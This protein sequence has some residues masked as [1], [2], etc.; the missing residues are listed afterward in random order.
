MLV[1]Y[2]FCDIENFGDQLNKLIFKHFTGMDVV[3]ENNKFADVI[4]IGSIL[5]GLLLQDERGAVSSAPLN[6]FSSGF[7]FDTNGVLKRCLMVFAVRGK[8][9]LA[10]LKKLDSVDFFYKDTVL[11][12]GGVLVPYLIEGDCE[13]IYDLGIV[14]HYADKDNKV[15]EEIKNA[16]GDKAVILDP[17]E[18]PIEFLKKLNKC[19]AVI[20]T[21][22][23]PLIACDALRIPNMWV[24][25]S[26][27]TTS[28]FKFDDYYS[29]FDLEKQPYDLSRGFSVKDLKKVYECYDITDEAVKNIQDKLI[30]A[31]LDIKKQLVGDADNINVRYKKHKR[32][33]KIMRFICAFIPFKSV[34]KIFRNKY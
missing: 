27:E 30:M 2:H 4:G 12:D 25:I 28:R 21:A 31:L 19:K 18:K 6:V 33:E 32:I 9:T 20:S 26:E 29:A 24:R 7:G 16:F 13:K 1:P 15:F 10:K 14:P 8:Y 23:H 22:M 11:G 3:K 17:T 5:D 34:R